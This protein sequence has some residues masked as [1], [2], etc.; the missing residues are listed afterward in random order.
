[1]PMTELKLISKQGGSLQ[2]LIEGVI[3]DA[4]RSTETGI[5][6]TEARLRSFEQQYQ[7]STSEFLE[8]Y[9]NDE[10]QETLELDEWI[11][12][13]RMLKR[14]Q[15]KAERLRGVELVY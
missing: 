6:Q 4:L 5:G 11:G 15:E 7:L 2:T 10:F 12:E 1:M 13:S 8:R 9:S 3:A 14:L